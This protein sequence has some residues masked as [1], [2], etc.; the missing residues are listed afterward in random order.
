[1]NRPRLIA[2][3]LDGTLLG[4]RGVL[5]PRTLSALRAAVSAGT[6]VV[7]VTARPPRFVDMLTAATG[8]VGTAVCSN[9]ALVYDVA[10]RIVVE[11]RALP[12]P[13]ARQVATALAA[14]A[15]GLGF[16]LETGHH[17]LYEPGFGL[18]FEG[19]AE[20][21]VAVA[22][23]VELWLTEVPVTKLLAWSAQL[24]AD[25]L[26]AAAEESAGGV[27]QFTHSGGRGL[28]E[29]SAPGVSKASTLSA[30]C[31]VRG[32]D[33]SDVV[34]FGDMPN[35]LAILQWAGTGYAMA[36]AH[37]AVLAAVGRH[38]ASNADD[39]VAVVLEEFFGRG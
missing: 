23:L 7:F 3:D 32:I 19:A 11:T 22:S 14:A 17:L 21:E 18:R 9:G 30:L 24:D 1:M 39:G 25:F 16:A 34:A 5:S 38:T 31:A 8:L 29:I 26:L 20:F 33:A 12:L 36:N 35:D 27:A 4:P 13:T 28:L 6:E 15:P 2:T 37:P 10:S